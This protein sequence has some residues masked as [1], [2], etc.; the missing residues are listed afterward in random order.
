MPSKK[1]VAADT[2]CRSLGGD[3]DYD[4]NT[5]SVS[6]K[7]E[8]SPKSVW[9]KGMAG[10]FILQ[11]G[12]G[13]ATTILGI[14]YSLTLIPTNWWVSYIL[15]GIM[16][17]ISS[18]MTWYKIGDIKESISRALISAATIFITSLVI[19]SIYYWNAA[20]YLDFEAL[21]GEPLISVVTG[22]PISSLLS[23]ILVPPE[24]RKGDDASNDFGGGATLAILG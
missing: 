10:F 18:G 9:G 24:E 4:D 8:N 23:I 22:L 19:G 20:L 11:V 13:T 7:P 2:L 21:S 3:F 6:L 15:L 16:I 14:Y 1:P 17:A 5:C 12:I